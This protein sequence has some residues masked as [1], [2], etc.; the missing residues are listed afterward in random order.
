MGHIHC[1]SQGIVDALLPARTVRLKMRK[2]ITVDF[3]GYKL[4]GVGDCGPFNGWSCDL[5]R[6]FEQRSRSISTFRL[7]V[8]TAVVAPHIW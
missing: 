8:K 6:R 4:L 2:D 7:Y 3:Q 5:L 1:G